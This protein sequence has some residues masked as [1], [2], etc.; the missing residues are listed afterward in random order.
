MRH[1]GHDDVD[2]VWRQFV[3]SAI[4][5]PKDCGP[6]EDYRFPLPENARTLARNGLAEA[7]FTTRPT[8]ERTW[9]SMETFRQ[10]GLTHSTDP[11][12]RLDYESRRYHTLDYPVERQRRTILTAHYAQ[13]RREDAQP[14]LQLI[15]MTPLQGVPSL[16]QLQTT[17]TA[18]RE[19]H[20]REE[21]QT[22]T[23]ES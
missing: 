19:H 13:I 2:S 1:D 9:K 8:D 22:Q 7:A 10:W 3:K 17:I 4:I 14:L 20:E 16:Q 18:I 15:E 5:F 6:P 23:D 11:A 12:F 21:N